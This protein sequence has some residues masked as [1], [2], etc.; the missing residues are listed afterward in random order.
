M[1]FSLMRRMM[2]IQVSSFSEGMDVAMTSPGVANVLLLRLFTEW[3]IGLGHWSVKVTVHLQQT[4]GNPD[5]R[6]LV[7]LRKHGH[8]IRWLLS[9]YILHI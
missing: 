9:L 2:G 8:G 4:W 3:R 7:T 5:S 1:S 6:G